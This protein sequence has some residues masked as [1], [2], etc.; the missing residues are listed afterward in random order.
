VPR[1]VLHLTPGDGPNVGAKLVA[2]PRIDGVVFT[3]GIDTAQSINRA[4]AKRDGPIIPLIAETGGI[5]AMIVDSTALSE[6]VVDDVVVSAFRSA[7]Q[8]CSALRLL[9]VQD[10]IADG[11][12]RMLVGKAR[13]LVVGDPADPATDVGP[14]IDREALDALQ[15]H[16]A[17]MDAEAQ[18]LF[19]AELGPACAG[20]TFFA[21]R[22]YEIQRIGQ[23][24]R[25]TFGPVLHVVRYA[26]DAID[27]VIDALNGLGYGLT[28]GIQSRVEAF[29]AMLHSRLRVGNAYVNR[30]IIGAVVGVQ[31]FGGE[32]LS[33]TGPKAGGPHYVAR[34][35]VERSLSVNTAAIGG[36]ASLLSS[37]SGP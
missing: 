18:L 25:E 20:G 2:D 3:G 31:P 5:N 21:P 8:R 6:Q 4:L 10:D 9:I 27:D 11:V 29:A 14:V 32:G 15:A 23:L 36:N 33:G 16:A 13:E 22:I 7:G 37:T 35:A 24:T 34:F 30:N 17:R 19:R 26:A 12:I 1:D 28:F